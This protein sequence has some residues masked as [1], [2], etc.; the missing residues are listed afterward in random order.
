MRLYCSLE[1]SLVG[2]TSPSTDKIN[3][4]KAAVQMQPGEPN[5]QPAGKRFL[6]GQE[7]LS[8]KAFLLHCAAKTILAVD[9]GCMCLF[10]LQALFS[11]I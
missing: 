9:N 1:R 7:L 2:M 4:I 5:S 6:H 8:N 10:L 3:F 11:R